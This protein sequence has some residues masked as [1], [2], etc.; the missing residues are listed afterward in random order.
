M[1]TGDSAGS[2]QRLWSGHPEAIQIAVHQS[3]EKIPEQSVT[4]R[5]VGPFY[6]G[7]AQKQLSFCMVRVRSLVKNSE[8][9]TTF[10]YV[11]SKAEREEL[12]TVSDGLTTKEDVSPG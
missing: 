10:L 1:F 5:R 11:R 2:N 7:F 8:A 6:K 12:K 9:H 3:V 4:N